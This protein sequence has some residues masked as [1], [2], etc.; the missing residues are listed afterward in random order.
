[1]LMMRNGVVRHGAIVS[2]KMR[3]G[4]KLAYTIEKE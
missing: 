3:G 2:L 4:L 1:M